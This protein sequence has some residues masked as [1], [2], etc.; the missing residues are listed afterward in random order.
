M[1]PQPIIS[2][3]LHPVAKLDVALMD[4]SDAT[5]ERKEFRKL[6]CAHS[7][8]VMARALAAAVLLLTLGSCRQEDPHLKSI[9]IL[10]AQLTEQ[11]RELSQ[12]KI[13]ADLV[14]KRLT[15]AERQRDLYWND[16]NNH[17]ARVQ[18]LTALIVTLNGRSP[19]PTSHAAAMPYMPPAATDQSVVYTIGQ[20]GSSSG[21]IT[22]D[23]DITSQCAAKWKTDY[24][25]VAYCQNEQQEAKTKLA[26]GNS[27]GISGPTFDEIRRGCTAK[28]GKDYRMRVYCEEEQVKAYKAT[29]GR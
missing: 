23:P 24:R 1:E 6:Y 4:G 9:E 25:M 19:A 14:A 28:W 29:G 11:D 26:R 18:E 10:K 22:N 16:A 20:S 15:E 8:E 5:G 7:R 17:K 13:S 27:H 21:S 2:I 3:F 12:L